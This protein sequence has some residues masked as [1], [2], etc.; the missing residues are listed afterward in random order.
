MG[1]VKLILGLLVIVGVIMACWQIVPP[2]L[3]NYQFQDDLHNLAM[4][5][6]SQPNRS[7]EDLR[8][9]VLNKAREHEIPLEGTQVTVQHIGT[10]GVPAVYFAADYNVPVNLPGYSFILHFTPTSGNKGF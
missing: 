8:N 6:A 3:A 2:E 1:T 4:M 10:P 7:D 9:A 5:A